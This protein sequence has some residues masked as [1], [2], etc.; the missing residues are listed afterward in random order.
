MI[1]H[2]VTIVV[3]LNKKIF[4]L[5]SIGGAL[6]DDILSLKDND[7]KLGKEYFTKVTSSNKLEDLHV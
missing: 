3:L 7:S 2:R 1:L 4:R 6:T 5:S